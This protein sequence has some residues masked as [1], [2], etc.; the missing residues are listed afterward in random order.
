[1]LRVAEEVQVLP[2]IDGREDQ[3]R[4][5]ARHHKANVFGFRAGVEDLTLA[6]ID[7]EQT[8]RRALKDSRRSHR[9]HIVSPI[10]V[11][12]WRV[13]EGATFL[14]FVYRVGTRVT[15]KI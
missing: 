9:V 3:T 13:A 1:P 2:P 10:T 14:V 15:P 6:W 8:K 7:P 11:G 5:R 12:F 4:N